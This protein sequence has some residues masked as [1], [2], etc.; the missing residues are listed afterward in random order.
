MMLTHSRGG[1]FAQMACEVCQNWL[2]YIKGP[3]Y[4]CKKCDEAYC[5][6]CCKK[7]MEE[8]DGGNTAIN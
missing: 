2:M 5:Q 6:N 4:F 3:V 7:L 1:D 8:E